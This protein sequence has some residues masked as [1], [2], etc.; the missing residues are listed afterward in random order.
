MGKNK[1]KE[2]ETESLDHQ[3]Q[4]NDSDFIGSSDDETSSRDDESAMSAAYK[5]VKRPDSPPKMKKVQFLDSKFL[6]GMSELNLNSSSNAIN[7]DDMESEEP[8]TSPNP[9]N[10]RFS[11]SNDFDKRSK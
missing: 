4:L 5:K 8:E 11:L 2:S 1:R 7:K 9:S 3:P 10:V 6:E